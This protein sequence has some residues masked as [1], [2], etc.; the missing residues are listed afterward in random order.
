MSKSNLKIQAQKLRL[1]GSPIGEIAKTLKVSKSSASLW[2]K[3]VEISDDVKNR[4]RINYL[5]KTQ[6]GRLIGAQLNKDK[7]IKSIH[8]ANLKGI[9]MINK[10]SKRD[11]LLIS[12]ALYW[13]EGSKS[14][15]S[16][17]FRFINSDPDMILFIK[18][19]LTDN[20]NIKNRDIVC[21]IQIN[22]IHKPRIETVLNF[23]KNL[24]D[25]DSEQM[26]KPYYIKAK[27]QKT[28]SN[29]DNYYGICKLLVKKSTDLKYLMIGLIKA[30]KE[31]QMST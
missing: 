26:R 29:H 28:Y 12:S 16:S 10:L 11:I 8:E 20:L 19:F 25:L 9:S 14:E 31:N 18:K 2:C 5:N 13:S 6:K 23:W 21:S 7:K 22:E 17:G 1:N 24:L 4:M 27:P 15:S 30:I 3:E